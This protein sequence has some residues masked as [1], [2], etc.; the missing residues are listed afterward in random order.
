MP[1]TVSAWQG[2]RAIFRG[3]GGGLSL[4]K[5]KDRYIQRAYY[6]LTG[7]KTE[8]QTSHTMRMQLLLV[9]VFMR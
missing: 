3:G 9:S 6:I 1:V 2:R 7:P 4:T 8:R 5:R